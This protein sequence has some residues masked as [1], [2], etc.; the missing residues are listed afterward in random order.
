MQN[1]IREEVIRNLNMTDHFIK[2]YCERIWKNSHRNEPKQND[3]TNMIQNDMM[4][5]MLNRE[6]AALGLIGYSSR[7][8]L[9][10]ERYNIIVISN[11]TLITIY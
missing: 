2:R 4:S 5:R 1:T 7:L 10:F 6:I 3:L 11:K 9:P 8:K